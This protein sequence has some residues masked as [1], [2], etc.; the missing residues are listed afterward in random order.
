MIYCNYDYLQYI[1]SMTYRENN[2]QHHEEFYWLG[3]YLKR[4]VALYSSS[5]DRHVYHGISNMM[6]FENYCSSYKHSL[7]RKG[8]LEQRDSIE[9][10]SPLSTSTSFEVALNF[11]NHNNGIV[12][13][14]WGSKER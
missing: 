2:G 9:I 10:C 8:F 13:E 5:T 6:L 12:V 1:F 4:T 11:A 3:K 7:E 14:F